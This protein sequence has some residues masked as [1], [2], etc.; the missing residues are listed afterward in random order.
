[1]GKIDINRL[2]ELLAPLLAD[3]IKQVITEA[4]DDDDPPAGFGHDE[5]EVTD[6]RV[7]S[8]TLRLMRA[9]YNKELFPKMYNPD[10]PQGL[11]K[12][13]LLPEIQRGLR[14]LNRESNVWLDL[15]ARDQNGAEFLR[16]AVD[17]FGLAFRT[18][19]EVAEGFIEGGGVKEDGAPDEWTKVNPDGANL[20]EHVWIDSRGF[21]LRAHLSREG[22]F[23]CSGSV[24]GVKSNTFTLKVS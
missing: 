10:N 23:V 3:V 6:R 8:V 13:A 22:D 15:T 4:M 24:A 1:M 5:P 9:Q 19:H 21:T 11:Y 20:S 14:R 18:R 16:D 2:I 7:H 17:A 12:N